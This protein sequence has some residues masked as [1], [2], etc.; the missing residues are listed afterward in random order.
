MTQN[1]L[2]NPALDP[3]VELPG[4]FIPISAETWRTLAHVPMS[5]RLVLKI[6]SR[7]EIGSLVMLLPDGRAL[8]HVGSIEGPEGVLI[9]RNYG[10]ASRTFH[11]GNIGF[12]EAYMAGDWDSPDPRR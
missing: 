6:I 9:V 2:D 10:F 8:R 7:L 5:F 11:S 12:G 1:Q 3:A 4:E